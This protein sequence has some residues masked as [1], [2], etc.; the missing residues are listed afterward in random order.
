[1]KKILLSSILLLVLVGATSLNA[2]RA[3][4]RDGA[5]DPVNAETSS[6]TETSTAAQGSQTQTEKNTT[7]TEAKKEAESKA[8]EA[9]KEAEAK[10]T[11]GLKKGCEQRKESINKKL[12]VLGENAQ[13]HQEAYTALLNKAIELKTAKSLNPVN[14]DALVATAN[15]AKIVSNNSIEALKSSALSVDCASSDI[16]GSINTGKTAAKAAKTTADKVKT[17]LKAYRA[18]VKAV[19][20]ALE[21]VTTE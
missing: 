10:K 5:D 13:K 12:S 4:A 7:A 2:S 9:K 20:V 8:V 16:G 15:A 21:N 6:S 3:L 17:D 19:L 1:M 14:F 11:E 18:A